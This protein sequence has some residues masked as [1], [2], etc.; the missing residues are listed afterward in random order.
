M[1]HD[2]VSSPRRVTT[3]RM[4]SPPRRPQRPS[5]RVSNAKENNRP[6]LRSA[7]NTSESNYLSL[8]HIH[9]LT[10][11]ITHI[12]SRQSNCKY[13]WHVHS[14]KR[15]CTSIY[16]KGCNT[17]LCIGCW[18][19]WHSWLKTSKVCCLCQ[20]TCPL[21][22]TLCVR[23]CAC[24]LCSCR[25]TQ[26]AVYSPHDPGHVGFHQVPHHEERFFC[27]LWLETGSREARGSP[28]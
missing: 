3:M 1:N 7:A 9:T 24:V 13:F 25:S 6:A 16:C 11:H 23:V 17:P 8:T 20:R 14:K 12:R 18:S 15:T 26:V 4:S 10:H 21:C 2:K 28:E 27:R 19:K 22:L 5:R